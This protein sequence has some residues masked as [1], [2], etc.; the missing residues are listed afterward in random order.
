LRLHEF[1]AKPPPVASS[2]LVVIRWPMRRG[3]S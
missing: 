1:E 3:M 2:G